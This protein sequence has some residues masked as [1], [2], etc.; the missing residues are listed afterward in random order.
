MRRAVAPELR[1]QPG[2][3]RGQWRAIALIALAVIATALAGAVASDEARAFYAVL[4]KPV[5]APPADVFAPVWT[6][7]YV[8]MGIAAWWV[9]RSRGSFAAAGLPLTLFFTQLVLNGLWSWLFFRWHMG[10]AALVDV[11]LLWMLLV[12][13]LCAFWQVRRSAAALL[14][15]YL[16][17]TGFATALTAAAW[18]LNPALL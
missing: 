3:P 7:L 12:A 11:A 4:A 13:T 10:G 1:V 15:P 6:L 2:P 16:L 18:K 9:W 17:W 8:L 14:L 5:W